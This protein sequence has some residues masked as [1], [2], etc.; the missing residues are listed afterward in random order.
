MHDAIILAGGKNTAALKRMTRKEYEA[1]IDIAGEPMVAFVARTLAASKNI[2]RILVIGPRLELEKISLPAQ[3]R[4]LEGG[5]TLLETIHLGIAALGHSHKTLIATADI[6]LISKAAVD[7][8]IEACT[9][10]EADFYYPIVA[11][12]IHNRYY[13][14]NK[15]TYVA[16]QEGTFTGG[17]L[18]MVKPDIVPKCLGFA[19]GIINKR[20]S[21]FALCRIMG[22]SIVLRFICK[23]LTIRALEQRFLEISGVTGTVIRT[24][25]PEIGIDVDK[26]QDLELVQ[27]LLRRT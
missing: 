8:F 13:P 16:L 18:F 27:A 4:V 10:K 9:Q 3:V 2:G 1:L 12:E 6:P 22:W 21:P 24:P 20:K 5:C 14:N 23:Q 15:R 11:K 19:R 7:H 25:Y 26:P 17:N